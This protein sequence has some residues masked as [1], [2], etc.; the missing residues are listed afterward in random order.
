MISEK[1]AIIPIIP[2]P[3]ISY[4]FIYSLFSK[5]IIT[6]VRNPKKNTKIYLYHAFKIKRQCNWDCDITNIAPQSPEAPAGATQPTILTLRFRNVDGNRNR[7]R[8]YQTISRGSY[9]DLNKCCVRVQ[10]TV[11]VRAGRSGNHFWTAPTSRPTAVLWSKQTK[12]GTFDHPWTWTGSC[13]VPGYCETLG[14]VLDRC[15][16]FGPMGN[17]KN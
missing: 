15:G 9:L 2:Y 11:G 5:Q 17:S 13:L 14:L 8:Q 1:L 6:E 12:I 16:V 10:P 4:W 7:P 3:L